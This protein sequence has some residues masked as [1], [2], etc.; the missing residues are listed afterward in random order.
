MRQQHTHKER[1]NH[2]KTSENRLV[3]KSD[4]IPSGGAEYRLLNGDWNLDITYL[5]EYEFMVQIEVDGKS[6]YEETMVP[7]AKPRKW[8]R[9]GKSL[10]DSL[11]FL[12]F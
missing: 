2:E 8:I 3:P 5:D 12:T 10:T 6:V 7:S 11:L 4:Y 1:I 9:F